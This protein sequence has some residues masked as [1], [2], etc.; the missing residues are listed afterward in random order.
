MVLTLTPALEAIVRI[1]ASENPFSKNSFL[2]SSKIDFLMLSLRICIAVVI[3]LTKILKN[4]VVANIYTAFPSLIVIILFAP[5]I[6]R[7]VLP[8]MS[9][10]IDCCISV[11]FSTSSDADASSKRMIGAF[12]R[13]ARAMEIL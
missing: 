12:L 3:F 1:D 9:F 7:T 5:W 13:K 8:L 10:E 2:A 6:V 11:S 4:T